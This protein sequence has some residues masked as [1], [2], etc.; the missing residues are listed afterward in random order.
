MVHCA[1]DF[2]ALPMNISAVISTWLEKERS[3]E[4]YMTWESIPLPNQLMRINISLVN[5]TGSGTKKNLPGQSGSWMIMKV[6]MSGLMKHSFTV[7]PSQKYL[8]I[9]MLPKPGSIGITAR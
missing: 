7:E 1:A 5:Y 3:G 9:M 8:L 4:N 6:Y 2:A